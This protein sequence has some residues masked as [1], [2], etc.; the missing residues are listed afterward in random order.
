[1]L[2]LQSADAPATGSRARPAQ[3]QSRRFPAEPKSPTHRDDNSEW[4]LNDDIP[5]SRDSPPRAQRYVRSKLPAR[6]RLICF[7]Y[8]GGS[9]AVY[10]DVHHPEI[11]EFLEIRKPSGDFN[12]KS[13]NLH[14]GINISDEFMEAVRDGRWDEMQVYSKLVEASA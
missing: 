12:R 5:P 7:P 13:L 9:A 8:A 3:G 2:P 11:E 1:M 4:N 6:M 14:H 10:L